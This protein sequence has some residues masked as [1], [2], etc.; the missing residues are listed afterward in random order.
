MNVYNI[1]KSDYNNNNN[2]NNNNNK[3][4]SLSVY[5]HTIRDSLILFLC[6]SLVVQAIN[7]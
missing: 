6:I 1:K 4:S 5:K 7:L 2:N 3:N